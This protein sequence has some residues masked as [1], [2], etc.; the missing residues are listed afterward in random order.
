MRQIHTLPETGE[1]S[2]EQGAEAGGGT[3]GSRWQEGLSFVGHWEKD[4]E[5]PEN[6]DTAAKGIRR[7]R[8]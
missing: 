6:K 5:K 7:A 3:F 2:E 8:V 4:R 1:D